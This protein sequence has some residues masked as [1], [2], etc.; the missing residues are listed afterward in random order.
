[1]EITKKILIIFNRY[2][3][4]L[5][6]PDNIFSRLARD[7]NIQ[8][9]IALCSLYEKNRPRLNFTPLNNKNYNL[10]KLRGI[11]FGIDKHFNL[12]IIPLILCGGYDLVIVGGYSFPSVIIAIIISKLF[13][14]KWCLLID[15]MISNSNES[16]IKHYIKK[17]LINGAKGYLVPDEWN[18][19]YLTQLYDIDSKNIFCTYPTTP[20][21][22]LFFKRYNNIELSKLRQKLNIPLS[23]I[24]ILYVGRLMKEKGVKELLATYTEIL[25]EYKIDKLYLVYL[26]YGPLLEELKQIV[27]RA[28]LKTVKFVDFVPHKQLPKYYQM[29]DIFVSFSYHDVW[30]YTIAEAAA[31]GLPII[32]T[33]AVASAK[34]FVIN[35]FNGFINPPGDINALKLSLVQLIKNERLRKEFAQNATKIIGKWTNN[36][37]YLSYL[38]AMKSL[39]E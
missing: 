28:G 34:N 35:N 8:I 2:T 33:E 10:L 17:C 14:K 19:Q 30:G 9:D 6:E 27:S 18:A 39:L 36:R 7:L 26:G 37:T 25:A 29:A 11:T 4:D 38:K 3:P 15:G 12:G 32:T 31:S 23:A 21:I 5:S 1:M 16:K 22:E 13:H 24:V 20:E